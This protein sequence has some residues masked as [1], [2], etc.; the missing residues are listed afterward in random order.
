MNTSYPE[1][2]AHSVSIVTQSSPWSFC[3]FKLWHTCVLRPEELIFLPHRRD[4]GNFAGQ[5][6][7]DGKVKRG[8]EAGMSLWLNSWSKQ[9]QVQVIVRS[10]EASSGIMV[11]KQ[12]W[13]L[14]KKA[15]SPGQQLR[16]VWSSLSP[17]A[18]ACCCD[19]LFL[20]LLNS[21]LIEK[22]RVRD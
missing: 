8:L 2:H 3:L 5:I 13:C 18:S 11:Q 7:G 4:E 21:K 6:N 10:V 20:F 15:F 22:R 17:C 12:P 14:K 1:K 16:S 19:L 9:L